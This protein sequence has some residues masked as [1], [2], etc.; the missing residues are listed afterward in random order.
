MAGL[1][2][3][4]RLIG[5]NTNPGLD[6]NSNEYVQTGWYILSGDS[7]NSPVTSGLI[8]LEVFNSINTGSGGSSISVVQKV[9]TLSTGLPNHYIRTR[10]GAWN[11]WKQIG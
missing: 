9:T 11:D 5:D 3:P 10:W 6:L 4:M 8:L 1:I 7:A 2:N